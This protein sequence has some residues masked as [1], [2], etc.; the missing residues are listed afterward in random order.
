MNEKL[1]NH[2]PHM[3]GSNNIQHSS[4]PGL[5]SIACHFVVV[6][7]LV[8]YHYVTALHSSRL[9]KASFTAPSSY[10]FHWPRLVN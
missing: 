6:W 7:D 5:V 2:L 9:H 10:K 3:D 1:V 4:T 8:Y